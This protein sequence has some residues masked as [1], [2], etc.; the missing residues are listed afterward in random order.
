MRIYC[1]RVYQS[2]ENKMIRWLGHIERMS[3]ERMPKMIL[4]AK[5]DSERKEVDQGSDGLMILK[6]I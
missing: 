1:S 3:E 5:I 4:N 2:T 6:L